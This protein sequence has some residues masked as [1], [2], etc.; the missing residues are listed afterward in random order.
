M[1]RKPKIQLQRYNV[2]QGETGEKTCEWPKCP[3]NG[4]FHAPKSRDDLK[5]YRWFCLDHIRQYNKSWNYYDGM[6]DF[7][8]EA[9]KRHDT[10][11]NRPT[12][13]IGDPESV[14]A[15]AYNR[16]SFN[17]E[18]LNDPF[19]VFGENGPAAQ[20]PYETE[21][22]G[23]TQILTTEQKTATIVFDL[24]IPFDEADVKSRYKELVK[25]HHPDAAGSNKASEEKI[26][27]INEAYAILLAATAP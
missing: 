5:S 24:E 20:N 16:Y 1:V 22:S 17:T 12:W 2:S 6:D 11:W 9:D 14:S 10:V 19:G 27:Q 21:G 7:E 8:V 26:R 15:N 25:R 4:D 18:N 3:E 13:K 23:G